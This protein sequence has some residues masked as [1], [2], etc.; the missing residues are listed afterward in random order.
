MDYGEASIEDEQSDTVR[1]MT[2]H[3]S[4]GLEFPIVFVV[5]MNKMFNSSDTKGSMV[6]HPQWGV[7]IDL[8][9]L[10]RRTKAPTIMKKIIQEEIRRENLG[11][12]LRVLYVALTRAKEKLIMTGHFNKVEEKLQKMAEDCKDPSSR[13]PLPYYMLSDAKCYMD[14]ILPL[15]PR[16]TEDVPITVHVTDW[17]DLTVQAK[18][19]EEADTIARDVLEHWNTQKVYAP[20]LKEILERQLGYQY[21]FEIEGRRKVKFTVTEL[22]KMQYAL[23]FPE[24][25]IPQSEENMFEDQKMEAVIPKFVQEEEGKTGVS[26][27]V[28]GTAY[29]R[30]MELLDFKESY[31]D[32]SLKE[33]IEKM[34]EEGRLGKDQA[35]MLY[36]KDILTFLKSRC[37]KRMQ[38]AAQKGLLRKEQ[39]F[40]IGMSANELYPELEKEE[41]VLVQG[42]IDV[43]FEE[44][45]ELVVLDYKTDRVKEMSEL[46]ER[47]HAQLDYYAKALEQL[48]NKKVKEKIIYS[49]CLCDEMSL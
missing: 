20:E 27:A 19:E 28:R 5:G 35:S 41:Q 30:I 9:D 22:K 21:P 25:S 39:P 40:I 10:E 45:G 12:E 6:I 14:W 11:E 15:I 46:K 17:P 2:I 16:I 42:V 24:D 18:V 1:I 23:E 33:F 36:R 44:D 38:Q 48:L 26:G 34:T 47:Y 49:F 3:K 8:I 31:T 29:H 13:I 32:A 4:K 43:C 7:G 37:A